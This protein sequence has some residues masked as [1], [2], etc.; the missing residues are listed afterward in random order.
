M[1]KQTHY[2][3]LTCVG[4]DARDTNALMAQA[5]HLAHAIFKGQGVRL[6]MGF[7]GWVDPTRDTQG[8]CVKPG[9]CGHIIRAYGTEQ[10]CRVVLGQLTANRLVSRGLIGASGPVKS[11]GEATVMFKRNRSHERVTNNYALR[12]QRRLVRKAAE[13]HVLPEPTTSA[14]HARAAAKRLVNWLTLRSA[15]NGHRFSL[16]IERLPAAQSVS[17]TV[18]GYGLGLPVPA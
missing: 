15:T 5:M 1:S 3:E 10:E 8:R 9:T 13:G 12:E 17:E 2:I 7:P 11:S 16:A 6:A 14:E 4:D 18:D